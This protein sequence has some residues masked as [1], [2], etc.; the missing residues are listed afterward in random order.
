ML[1]CYLYVLKLV[2]RRLTNQRKYIL[3]NRC[4]LSPQPLFSMIISSGVMEYIKM[5][6]L[7]VLLWIICV[8]CFSCFRVC[9]L[10]PCGHLLGKGCPLGSCW[11]CL[12]L[13]FFL[14]WHVASLVR[15]GAWLY[16]FLI[17][18]VFLTLNSCKHAVL[19]CY[20]KTIA[21]VEIYFWNIMVIQCLC[22]ILGSLAYF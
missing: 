3:R 2:L 4:L 16:R 22:N 8:L 20:I 19:C 14:L 21:K 12:L 5:A 7:T 11:W 1:W 6:W 15:C 10:L 17:F 18:A 13:L 9:S